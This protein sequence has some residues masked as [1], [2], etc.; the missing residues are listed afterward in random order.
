M[1]KVEVGK[2]GWEKE[3]IKE[4]L[5]ED[6]KQKQEETLSILDQLRRTRKTR[7]GVGAPLEIPKHLSA[8]SQ[9]VVTDADLTA[10]LTAKPIAGNDED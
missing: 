3:A 5:G 8:G 2:T 4:V 7:G 9:I 6:L 1:G 10:N